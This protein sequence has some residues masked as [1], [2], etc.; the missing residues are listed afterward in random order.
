M[1]HDGQV[2]GLALFSEELRQAWAAAGLTQDQL[3]ER[4]RYSPSLVAHV[5]TGSQ[6]RSWNVLETSP[7]WRCCTT[8]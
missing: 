1:G 8:Y 3:A 5:E 2:S 7:G 6:G 4:I